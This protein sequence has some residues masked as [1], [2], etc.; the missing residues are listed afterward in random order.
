MLSR[1][2]TLFPAWT[3]LGAAAAY[4]WPA[5]FEAWKPAIVYLLGLVMFGMGM[6]LS[7]THFAETLR[8]PG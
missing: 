3:L 5:V 1:A 2:T 6:T 8:R 4:A 7:P